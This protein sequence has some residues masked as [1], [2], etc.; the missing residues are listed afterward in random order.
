M[1][2]IQLSKPVLIEWTDKY[3]RHES[4]VDCHV[5]N[6]HIEIMDNLQVVYDL[7]DTFPLQENFRFCKDKFYMAWH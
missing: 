1:T 6:V 5:S 4:M 7:L 3:V 2:T